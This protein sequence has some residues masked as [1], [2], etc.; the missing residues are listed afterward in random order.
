[1]HKLIVLN[2]R[3]WQ[4]EFFVASNAVNGSVREGRAQVSTGSEPSLRGMAIAQ[5]C[6]CKIDLYHI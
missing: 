3:I 1:M 6:V 5:S 4:A 2:E